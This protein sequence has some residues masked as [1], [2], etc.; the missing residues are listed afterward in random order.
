MKA[1]ALAME[2]VG[3]AL[4]VAAI[5]GAG[6]MASGS[7][8]DAA[9]GLIMNA[10]S[11]TAMLAIIIR[12]G[13]KISGAHYNPAVTFALL[14][15]KKV[16]ALTSITYIVAQIAGAIS[17]AF[18]ANAM[19]GAHIYAISTST[20]TNSVLI[21]SE[22]VATAGLVWVILRNAK[23]ANKVALFVPLWIFS[24]YFF[25]SSTSFANPAATIGRVFTQSP[26]GIAP[27]SILRFISAQFIGA[28]VGWA[29][30]SFLTE[31]KALEITDDAAEVSS[32][33]A[34]I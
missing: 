23:N 27:A 29:L 12:L 5:L 16:D 7:T 6:Y 11:A 34:A 2:F 8:Q 22:I 32:T 10:F 31:E 30:H 25:T 9:V 21:I 26:A 15:S 20:R 14:L 18:L 3:T 19:Y 13:A 24:A 4:L 33:D 1:K 28:A 17:G